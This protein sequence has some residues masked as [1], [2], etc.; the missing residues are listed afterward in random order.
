MINR[1]VVLDTNIIV[2]AGIQLAGPSAKIVELVLDGELM[3]FTCPAVIEEYLEVLDRPRFKKH[4]FSPIWI[5]ALLE[6]GN[7]RTDDPPMW[8]FPGP[9]PDDLVFLAQSKRAGAVLVT[10]NVA[11]YPESI[12]DGVVVQTPR[13]YLDAWIK[14]VQG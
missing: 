1:A 7:F 3:M 9:D 6:S 12:S 14:S 2:S 13:A 5:P 4:M 10:G 11:D 8:P